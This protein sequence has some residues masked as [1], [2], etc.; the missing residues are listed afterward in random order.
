VQRAVEFHVQ[1]IA[2]IGCCEPPQSISVLMSRAGAHVASD[3]GL[4]QERDLD[5]RNRATEIIAA[6]TSLADSPTSRPAI[7]VDGIASYR[8]ELIAAPEVAYPARLPSCD[9]RWVRSNDWS[10]GTAY[11]GFQRLKAASSLSAWADESTFS[12]RPPGGEWPQNEDL[13][14]KSA[15]RSLTPRLPG[16]HPRPR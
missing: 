14:Q 7:A 1:P 15:F 13:P 3:V 6:A 12:P 11:A 5:L 4:L 8:A 2:R 10:I 16:E 9:P